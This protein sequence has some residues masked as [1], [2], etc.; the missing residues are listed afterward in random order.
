MSD[1]NI[2]IHPFFFKEIKTRVNQLG[3]VID[4]LDILVYYYKQLEDPLEK[5]VMISFEPRQEYFFIAG[6]I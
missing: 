1:D 5:F 3:H 6:S 4:Q 2:A